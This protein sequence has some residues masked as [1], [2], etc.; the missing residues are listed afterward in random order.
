M[1]TSPSVC[2]SPDDSAPPVIKRLLRTRYSSL[3]RTPTPVHAI[4]SSAKHPLRRGVGGLMAACYLRSIASFFL[5]A[6]RLQGG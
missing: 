3:D 5:R 6:G 1:I 2:G 4:A